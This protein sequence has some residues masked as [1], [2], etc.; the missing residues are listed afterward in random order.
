MRRSRWRWAGVAWGILA[1]GFA[2]VLLLGGW[3]YLEGTTWI[4]QARQTRTLLAS[5]ATVADQAAYRTQD[6]GAGGQFDVNA[7]N[8]T[9]WNTLAAEWPITGGCVPWTGPGS[10][11]AQAVWQGGCQAVRVSPQWAVG[12]VM[13]VA[14]ESVN[15]Q[16]GQAVVGATWQP[17][18]GSRLHW[19][20][21]VTVPVRILVNNGQT[22]QAG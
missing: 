3:I 19:T 8:T 15:A 14:I 5:A 11:A 1:L 17:V 22:V 21:T 6:T 2:A 18:L 16:T 13:D 4:A 10:A 12:G 20:M 7:F 9:F